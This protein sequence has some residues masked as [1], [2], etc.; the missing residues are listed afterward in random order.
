MIR[1][2]ININDIKKIFSNKKQKIKYLNQLYNILGVSRVISKS[3][4]D[5][6]SEI[7]DTW[8]YEIS[9]KI[10]RDLFKES[11]K[12]KSGKSSDKLLKEMMKQWKDLKLGDFDWPFYPNAFDQH[13]HSINVDQSL[14]EIEKDEKVKDEVVRFR[15]IKK[16][17]TARNDYIEYL[18]V[19][20]NPNVT[21]TLKH[22]RCVDFYINGC[23]FDQKV[24]RSVTK[25]FIKDFGTNW[26]EKAIKNPGL[27]AK[28]L[29]EYQDEARFGHESRLLIVYL[30]EDI[31]NEDIKYCV[32]NVNFR[33]PRHISFE[34]KHSSGEV[35]I[36][37]VVC[38]IILLSKK[39]SLS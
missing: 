16:I 24:S 15:R 23:S 22:N 28:Y 18:I 27:V 19:E 35:K 7:I 33:K 36:Y 37:D 31:T 1:D 30:D 34:Y 14:S 39:E 4:D 10:I 26:R 32:K 2:S 21:P 9:I 25:N 13:V 3:I 17:N 6:D 5:I 38:Y 11:D 8:N 29:Y 20:N 12:Y